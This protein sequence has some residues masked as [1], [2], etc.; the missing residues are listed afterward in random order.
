MSE[1]NLICFM[2]NGSGCGYLLSCID[3]PKVMTLRGSDWYGSGGGSLKLSIREWLGSKLRELQ[4]KD[5]IASWLC[6]K[7]W[8]ENQNLSK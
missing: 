7:E 3:A 4:L 8:Q 2:L 1:I 5:T 6:L